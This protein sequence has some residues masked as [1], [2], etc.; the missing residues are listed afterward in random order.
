MFIQKNHMALYADCV[1]RKQSM[2]SK[3]SMSFYQKEAIIISN[4]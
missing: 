2:H 4:K 3:M 1:N